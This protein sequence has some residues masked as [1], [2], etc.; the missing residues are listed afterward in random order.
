MNVCGDRR[1]TGNVDGAIRRRH[2]DP[3]VVF[4]DATNPNVIC[5]VD[6]SGLRATAASYS[7]EAPSVVT[8]LIVA[9][10]ALDGPDAFHAISWILLPQALYNVLLASG[11][12][13][14]THKVRH[15]FGMVHF[16][17]RRR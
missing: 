2:G 4:Y 9:Y 6:A 7:A 14:L 16:A 10:P 13:W 5:Y 8:S 11:I 1:A 15:S 17:Q 12:F 3:L